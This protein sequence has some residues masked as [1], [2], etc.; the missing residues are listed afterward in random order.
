MPSGGV[1]FKHGSDIFFK[2]LDK[3]AVNSAQVP[4]DMWARVY[5]PSFIKDIKERSLKY[6]Q[7]SNARATEKTEGLS[8]ENMSKLEDAI[9]QK[10]V[11][12]GKLKNEGT[13]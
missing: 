2:E 8:P 13:I 11:A 1:Y 10:A 4:N 12:V 5:G 7:R 9:K 3:F 6:A